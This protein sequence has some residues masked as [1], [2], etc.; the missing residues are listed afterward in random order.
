MRS[1]SDVGRWSGR[2]AWVLPD[3]EP[4]D[5]GLLLLIFL[6]HTQWSPGMADV[7]K[8]GCQ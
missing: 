2:V 6:V 1:G 5:F 3:I 7:E 4:S 8:A